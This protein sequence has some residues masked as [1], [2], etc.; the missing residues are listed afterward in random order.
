MFS[1]DMAQISLVME[2]PVFK[3]SYQFRCKSGCEAT[4]VLNFPLERLYYHGSENIE[5]ELTDTIRT[6]IPFSKS[7]WEKN[8]IYK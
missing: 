7:K 3:V 6:K 8:L 4:E 5:T 2:K 1:Y